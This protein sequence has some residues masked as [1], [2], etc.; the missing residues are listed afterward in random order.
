M[1]RLVWSV[2]VIAAG[3]LGACASEDG[4]VGEQPG[5]LDRVDLRA[6]LGAADVAPI[7]VARAG[8]RT[9]VFDDAL[10]IHELGGGLAIATMPDPGVEVRFPFTDLAWLEGDRFVVTAIGDGFVL[11]AAAGT[12]E[13][14]FCYEPNPGDPGSQPW[15]D[16]EQ[17]TDAVAVAPGAGLIYAQPRTDRLSDGARLG[18]AIATYD[19]PTGAVLAWREL[20]PSFTARGMVLAHDQLLLA[21]GSTL[22]GFDLEGGVLSERTDLAR[23][24][25]RDVTG[26]A[27]DGTSLVVVDA[28]TDQLIELDRAALGL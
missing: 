5:V 28:G 1:N 11:D 25:A 18:S 2:T 14:R 8:E 21:S 19:A 26:L 3:F 22:Y 24:G 9:F 4:T 6:E 27:I 20:D 17:R 10:G 12:L 15:T 16:A 7:G 13:R 23:F